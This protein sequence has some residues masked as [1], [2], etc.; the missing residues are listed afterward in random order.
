MKAFARFLSLRT[1]R[2]A[3]LPED[4]N[5][6]IDSP[7]MI[8]RSGPMSVIA[9]TGI[10]CLSCARNSGKGQVT[11]FGVI[12]TGCTQYWTSHFMS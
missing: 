4:Q 2:H 11:M 9:S 12:P 8:V 7:H 10:G 6:A 3:L 5:A 1:L